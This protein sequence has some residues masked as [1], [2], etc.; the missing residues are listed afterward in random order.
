MKYLAFGLMA[1]LLL[2]ATIVRMFLVPSVM[3]MLGDDCWWAPRWMRRLQTRIGLGE[4]NLPDER[5]R[6]TVNGRP[7]RPPVEA[8]LVAVAA[9]PQP[10]HDPTHPDVAEARAPGRPRPAILPE[11]RPAPEVPSSASTTRIQTRP[12][13]EAVP[14]AEARTTRF[15]TPGNQPAPGHERPANSASPAPGRPPSAGPPTPSAGE[16]RG[17]PVSTNHEKKSDPADPTAA[18]PVMRSEGDDSEAATNKLNTR[19]QGD[20]NDPSRP[21]RRGAS[22][23][24]SAQ[25]LL[26]R[27]GRL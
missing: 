11:P 23:G 9:T 12:P 13:T 26:R 18:L 15:S 4:T 14:P 3:K 8:S 20:N 10:H 21:H 5:K 24:L 27:E 16:T 19:G 7:A 2:D 6:P 25:D 17:M 22:G 1:A